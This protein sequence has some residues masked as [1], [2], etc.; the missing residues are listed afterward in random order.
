MRRKGFTLIELLVVIAIIAIIAALLF[1]V[2]SQAREKARAASCMSNVRQLGFAVIMYTQD[3][4]DTYPILAYSRVWNNQL[5]SFSVADAIIPYGNFGSLPVC[6]SEP[7]AWNYDVQ[8]K[9]C[10]HG[11]LGVSMGNFGDWSYVVNTAVARPGSDNFA[12]PV[13]ARKPVRTV[14]ELVRPV[15]TDL[16]SDGYLC[17]PKCDPP[18]SRKNL[19]ATPGKAPRHHE[20]VNV[21][22][23]DGHAK[24]Q[25]ARRMSDDVWMV[26]GGPYDGLV[27]LKGIVRD[28]RSIEDGP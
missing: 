28:D 5:R 9:D 25:K 7:H 14:P 20:G 26:D 17:G 22:Y 13:P 15:D 27:E 8:L 16:Y 12:F 3:N 1:P 4:D 18:C 23:A 2:F 21:V 10:L 19:L 11:A 6:P 24:R